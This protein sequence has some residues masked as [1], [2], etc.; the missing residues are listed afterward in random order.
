MPAGRF[1]AQLHG[2]LR[3]WLR[4][5]NGRP[6]SP[7]EGAWINPEWGLDD[8]SHV[9]T[10]V[11]LAGCAWLALWGPVARREHFRR[12]AAL[13]AAYLLRVQR[14]GGLIDYKSCNF[15]SAPDT[16]FVVQLLAAVAEMAAPDGR[17][18]VVRATIETF[19]RRAVP[20]LC[21]GGFHTPNHRWVI[22]SALAQAAAL[23][24]DLTPAVASTLSAYR[25][26]GIDQ[27]AD[28]AY[29]ERS[30]AV[31]DAVTNRCLW[32]LGRHAG[33]REAP[34]AIRR[35]LRLNLH[36]LHPDGTIETALSR[37][38][39]RG[40]RVVPSALAPILHLVGEHALAA[41]LWQR[42]AAPSLTDCVWMVYAARAGGRSMDRMRR[43]VSFTRHLSS[44]GMWRV[45][46]PGWSASIFRDSTR[47]V[48]LVAGEIEL[49]G[50][51]IAQSYF[52]VGR[53]RA[54]QLELCRGGVVLRS[55][56]RHHPGRPGY[57]L[58]LGRPV[59][60]DRWEELAGERMV[61]SLPPCAS[62][63]RITATA[64]GLCLH[65]RTLGGQAGVPAQIALD[66]RPRGLWRAPGTECCMR[67][68]SVHFLD[69]AWAEV[70]SGRS[71]VRIEPGAAAHRMRAMRDAGGPEGNARVLLTF[72]TPV[73]FRFQV[74]VAAS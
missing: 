20:G 72:L 59:P 50:L 48:H 55:S 57:L 31:Y 28:G 49:S 32:F 67:P 36:L 27:D 39:D 42:A 64:D 18:E 4:E 23:W 54:E 24:P 40:W 16:A 45:G 15:D 29:Q 5:Q 46:R 58:P 7:T 22:C 69:S 25:A 2:A 62:E 44:L 10:S 11:L 38:Q 66:F 34:G 53:F 8:P 47:L 9:G 41:W 73:D 51:S 68:G 35:N 52:G 60:V 33:W 17:L 26:E 37:R 43:P 65:Y 13:A 14:P 71:V 63:L 19:I 3:P 30:P 70:R 6:G 1:L 21:S 12:R 74:S 56:G 61:R